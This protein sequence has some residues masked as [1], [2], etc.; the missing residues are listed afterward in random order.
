MAAVDTRRWTQ[1][2]I[3]VGNGSGMSSSPA[4]YGSGAPQRL[5]SASLMGPPGYGLRA[6][7]TTQEIIAEAYGR[8]LHGLDLIS[9][10]KLNALSA[11]AAKLEAHVASRAA[12]ITRTA[13]AASGDASSIT[14]GSA[15]SGAT[16]AGAGSALG[17][18]Q[19]SYKE[20]LPLPPMPR[21]SASGP[22]SQSSPPS[23]ELQAQTPLRPSSGQVGLTH[24]SLGQLPVS[25]VSTSPL[26]LSSPHP[27]QQPLAGCGA[28]GRPEAGGCIAERGANVVRLL[29]LQDK[30]LFGALRA[31]AAQQQQL[32][33]PGPAPPLTSAGSGSDPAG[34]DA[35]VDGGASTGGGGGSGA[36]SA[37][38]ATG[39]SG[40][41]ANAAGNC[42]G[43]VSSSGGPTSSSGGG[44]NSSSGGVISGGGGGGR[45]PSLSALRELDLASLTPEEHRRLENLGIRL[46]SKV[47]AATVQLFRLTPPRPL[48]SQEGSDSSRS[49]SSEEDPEESEANDYAVREHLQSAVRRA[50]TRNREHNAV[51]QFVESLQEGDELSLINRARSFAR[52]PSTSTRNPSISTRNPSLS[53]SLPTLRPATSAATSFSV[54]SVTSFSTGADPTSPS[55]PISAAGSPSAPPA[56]SGLS[57]TINLPPDARPSTPPSPP[58]TASAAITTTE[59]I[60]PA[61]SVSPGGGGWGAVTGMLRRGGSSSMVSQGGSSMQ[62]TPLGAQETIPE[63]DELDLSVFPTG[64]SHSDDL[65]DGLMK[66]VAMMTQQGAAGPAERLSKVIRE[67]SRRR[68]AAGAGAGAGAGTWEA[69]VT[70]ATTSE[71]RGGGAVGAAAAGGGVARVSLQ[72]AWLVDDGALPEV[73]TGSYGSPERMSRRLRKKAAL[74]VMFNPAGFRE[75]A[76]AAEVALYRKVAERGRVALACAGQH[77][78]DALAA[79]ALHKQLSTLHFA[80]PFFVAPGDAPPKKEQP[81]PSP[82]N[83]GLARQ[84]TVFK[85]S[86]PVES[87]FL[88]RA[89]GCDSEDMIDNNA[90][91]ER[92]VRRDWNRVVRKDSFRGLV[93]R[94][95]PG[96]AAGTTG[97]GHALDACL[98]VLLRHKDTMRS[99][100]L[101]YCMTAN[102]NADSCF[103]M[104]QHEWRAFVCDCG[105][106]GV[107]PE[108]GAGGPAGAAAGATAG[109]TAGGTSSS[110]TPNSTLT[111]SRISVVGTALQATSRLRLSNPGGGGT[112][113][114]S[115]AASAAAPAS[116]RGGGM[117]RA[118][119]RERDSERQAAS[120]SATAAASGAASVAS[121]GAGGG[122]PAAAGGGAAGAAVGLHQ[123]ADSVLSVVLAEAEK[124]VLEGQVHLDRALL[125]SEWFEAL[126]RLATARHVKGGDKCGSIAAALERMWRIDVL[127]ALPSA[128][129]HEPNAWRIG[130]LYDDHDVNELL[131]A[132]ADLITV[133]YDV[134]RAHNKNQLVHLSD[135][136]GLISTCGLLGE[137][138]GLTS[139]AAKLAFARSLCVVVDEVGGW[140]RAVCLDRCDLMEALARLAEEM[141][142]PS[143]EEVAETMREVMGLYGSS[144]DAIMVH[145]WLCYYTVLPVPILQT[146]RHAAAEA[147]AAA[148]AAAA[149]A[150]TEAARSAPNATLTTTS[151]TDT[152]NLSPGTGAGTGTTSTSTAAAALLSSSMQRL[153]SRTS[154]AGPGSLLSRNS[155][156]LVQRSSGAARTLASSAAAAAAAATAAPP[157]PEWFPPPPRLSSLLEALLDL[158]FGRL[159]EHWECK[160]DKQLMV[161]LQTRAKNLQRTA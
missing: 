6:R 27:Y 133:L 136:M 100:F 157:P 121:S 24:G 66:A 33:Q 46:D 11:N 73:F 106:T 84:N 97:L 127:P 31:Q 20:L 37:A 146:R 116:S 68:E 48:D 10:K 75:D 143:R 65:L 130:R 105:L 9:V 64:Q 104:G 88:P 87:V 147:A 51:T 34:G 63:E 83:R 128:A 110:P 79:E 60:S 78:Q 32:P 22:I 35:N 148:K 92:Q 54:R 4:Q 161:R 111:R 89:A 28:V 142:P 150:A 53:R 113:T 139:H 135:W 124:R 58:A 122:G 134:L 90:V 156:T 125:R 80:R 52:N 152:S 69:V 12:A 7:P 95:D 42:S 149:A 158:L 137:A 115:A 19:A 2:G 77:P 96:V 30:V 101:Y 62:G 102:S 3:P 59:P 23:P 55:T 85:Q 26:S 131:T 17:T 109:S 103:A 145:P 71:G 40:G 93:A 141:A 47:A 129:L 86:A 45:F 118:T 138:T 74:A 112:S 5:L 159:R 70:A 61:A 36:I 49:V 126:I 144:L 57:V 98:A 151:N 44:P 15:I 119:P 72:D 107:P 99:V 1:P 8:R 117:T 155:T 29:A 154:I 114:A 140:S 67:A 91:R 39:S 56:P 16:G 21:I 120:G 14:G 82:S 123:L 43:P 41:G 76:A 153:P 94:D 132:H 108:A 38:A 25:S 81:K 50:I 18:S 160:D 13:V